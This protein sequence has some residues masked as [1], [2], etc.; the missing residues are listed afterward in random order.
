MLFLFIYFK[1]ILSGEYVIKEE[2]V[3]EGL[4]GENYDYTYDNLT[5]GDLSLPIPEFLL[6]EALR[7][8]NDDSSQVFY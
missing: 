1:K 8:L 7:E 2:P 4:F 6:D 5:F 3:N